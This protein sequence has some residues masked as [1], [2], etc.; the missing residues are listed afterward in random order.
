[1]GQKILWLAIA[2]ALLS[3]GF[4][5]GLKAKCD[6]RP[7]L[8]GPCKRYKARWFYSSSL[9][10]CIMFHWGGCNRTENFFDNGGD[11]ETL[12]MGLGEV[13]YTE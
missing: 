11:C 4:S 2:I 12:C 9:K 7:T 8:T 13:K 10:E 5:T 6:K 1:M 3:L